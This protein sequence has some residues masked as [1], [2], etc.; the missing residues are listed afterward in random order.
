MGREPQ[1]GDASIMSRKHFI[2]GVVQ[3]AMGP[4]PADNRRHALDWAERAAREGAQVICLPELV[5]S[6]YLCQK[7]DASLFDLAESPDGPTA[8]CFAEFA[9]RSGTAV[10]VPFFERRA[11]GVHHNSVLVFDGDGACLGCYRKM[12]IPDDPGYYEKFYFAPGDLGFQV[13]HTQFAPVAPLICWDQWF[14]EAA[15]LAALR[16]AMALLYPTAIGWHPY[17]REQYGAAQLEAWVTVQRGHAVANSL[18]VAAAN[19]VGFEPAEGQAGIRFWGSS[20]IADPQG[21]ILARASS[22]SE[23][24][25]IADID[26]DHLETIRRNWHFFRDRRIDAYQGILRRFIDAPPGPGSLE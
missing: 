10:I 1:N 6:R 21:L 9:G 8:R 2:L 11:P 12:H 16:G 18:Y 23:E 4:D 26:L 22:D 14:P 25:L 7:E 24:V 3:M 5:S 20:F 17:E 13:F 15:R 19:R